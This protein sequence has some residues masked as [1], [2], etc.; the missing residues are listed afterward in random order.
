MLENKKYVLTVE[1]ETEQWYFLWLRDQINSCEG[2]TFNAAIDPKVKKS[3]KSFYKGTNSKVTPEAFHICDVESTDKYHIDNFENILKEM[4][5]AKSQKNI[6]YH[7]GYSNF[8]F[9]LWIILHKRDC[10]GPFSDRKQYLIP[11][12]QCFGEKFE[13]LDHYKHETAF[14]RCLSKLTID[15]VKAA[16]KRADRLAQLNLNDN[17]KIIKHS[18][19]SYYRENPAL[20]INEVVKKILTECGIM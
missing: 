13:D 3:P 14:K 2:R 17:K 19:Y 15:D 16:V 1:G 11:I 12:Q 10:F 4:K 9:E 6:K 5:E 7:L 8:T 20:S 18:G